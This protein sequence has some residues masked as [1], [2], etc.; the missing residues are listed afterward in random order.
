MCIDTKYLRT[1]R[2]A[3]FGIVRGVF[4]RADIAELRHACDSMVAEAS[5]HQHSF[6]NKN[7]F[8]RLSEH[9]KVGRVL[10]YAQWPSY[11]HPVFAKYRVHHRLLQ[12][13]GPLLDNNLKQIINTVFWK[14]PG[15]DATINYHQDARFRRPAE[16]YRHLASS[17]IQAAIAI[18]P[19]RSDNGCMKFF[20]GSHKLGDLFRD[21]TRT[22]LNDELN[23][24]DLRKVGLDPAGV[25]EILLDPGDVALWGPYMVHASGPNHSTI[26]RR[27]Y[28]NGY[29]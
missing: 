10:H 3:G 16:A 19:H 1:F 24:D 28:V 4:S 13:L 2:Q 26:T 20:P 11:T 15:N 27:S 23:E 21:Q 29:V 14:P 12:I 7:Q 25:V 9:S 5:K 6:R 22:V 8:F 17:Y 18:D